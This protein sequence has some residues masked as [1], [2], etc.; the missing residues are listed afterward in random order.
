M[1]EQ[2]RIRLATITERHA[3]RL[4]EAG[5]AGGLAAARRAEFLR[6]F[7]RACAEV[8]R[9][10]MEAIGAELTRA[11][12]AYRVEQGATGERVSIELHLLIT[13]APRSTDKVIRL[14]SSRG[15]EQ[16]PEV[17]AE[18]EME[19]NPMELTRFLQIEEI[20][21]EVVEQMLVDAIEQVFACNGG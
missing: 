17:V 5:D 15:P 6:G 13:G 21:P 16:R 8:L 10:A 20:T 3:R 19:R 4:S 12:H 1:K 11:G 7:E 2:T 14:F 18:V 9:P